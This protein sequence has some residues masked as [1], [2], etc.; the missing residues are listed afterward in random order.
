MTTVQLIG[1][2]I[3]IAKPCIRILSMLK[4]SRSEILVISFQK[5][6]VYPVLFCVYNLRTHEISMSGPLDRGGT[7]VVCPSND[8]R[9]TYANEGG[10]SSNSSVRK[11][12]RSQILKP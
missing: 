7:V 3:L 4:V 5:F 2:T 12:P 8:K 10:S 9:P 1:R 6:P 11:L